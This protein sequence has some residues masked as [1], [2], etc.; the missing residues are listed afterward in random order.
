MT[1]LAELSEPSSKHSSEGSSCCS[2]EE[3]KE[4]ESSEGNYGE[5]MFD[6]FVTKNDLLE[7]LEE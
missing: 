6:Q 4:E 5:D 3:E 2:S 7:S 1:S